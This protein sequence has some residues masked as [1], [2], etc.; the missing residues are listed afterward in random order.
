MVEPLKDFFSCFFFVSLGFHIFPT[1][2]KSELHT[3]A[4]FTFVTMFLKF[5][6]SYTVIGCFTEHKDINT[7]MISVGLSQ[8]SEFTFV[9]GSRGRRLRIISREVY[10]LML[11][12][13]IVSLLLTPFVWKM[14]VSIVFKQGTYTRTFGQ[15]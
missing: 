10:L 5:V 12:S 15:L 7:F 13:T 4:I 14:A 8:I 2:L 11:S 9:L 1:F 6:L 3:I